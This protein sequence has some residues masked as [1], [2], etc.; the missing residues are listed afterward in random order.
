MF[1]VSLR[2]KMVEVLKSSTHHRLALLGEKIE[3]FK[4]SLRE[5]ERGLEEEYYQSE[6]DEQMEVD[7]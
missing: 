3:E 2:R 6:P 4:S 1:L 5:F 7:E